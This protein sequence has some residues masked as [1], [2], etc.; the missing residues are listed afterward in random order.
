VRKLLISL[1][2]S[3]AVILAI[4]S[5]PNVSV[6]NA[7]AKAK[8]K[9][10]SLSASMA[11]NKRNVNAT[12]SNLTNVK[13]IKYQLTYSSNKGP[14]GAGGTIKVAKN[15]KSLSRSILLGTCSH[16]VCT[17]NTGIKNAKLSVDF[18]LN[19]GGVISYEKK[20]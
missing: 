4:P 2:L 17:Y 5:L 10:P 12:F 1:I 7:A 14:Q 6:A 11:K 20:L 18:V 3:V 19:S 13:S 15:S 16:K 9:S 8:S